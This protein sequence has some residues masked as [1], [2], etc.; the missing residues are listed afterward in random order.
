MAETT[1]RET[2]MNGINSVAVFCGS[3]LG[4]SPEYGAAARELGLGLGLAGIR[5]VYGGGRSGMMG[6]L[7]DAVLEAGG[8]VLGVIPRF[9]TKAEVAHQGVTEMLVVD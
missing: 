7:A 1:M 8:T 9:L 6:V 3:R 4:S 2:F 5:L